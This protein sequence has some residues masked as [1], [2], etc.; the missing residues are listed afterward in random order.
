MMKAIAAFTGRMP[1]TMHRRMF[2]RALAGAGVAVTGAAAAQTQA[3]VHRLGILYLGRADKVGDNQPDPLVA[4]LARLGLVEGVNLIIDVRSPHGNAALLDA[5]AAELVAARP[6]VLLAGSGFIS[7]LALKKATT[8]IPIVFNVGEPVAAGLVSSLAH[9]GG[10]LTGGT[11]PAELEFKR[12]QILIEVLG[13]SASIVHLT[14]PLSELRKASFLAALAASGMAPG[15]RLQFL[16]VSKR[17]DLAP[18]FEQMVRQ[19]VGGVAVRLTPLTATHSEEIAAL[20]VKHRLPAIG[21]GTDYTDLG[22]LM[23]Y[24]VD[25]SEVLRQ[26]AK[27]IQRILNGAQPGDLPI[28]QVTKFEFVVNLKTARTLGVRVPLSVLTRATRVVE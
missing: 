3:K 20:A 11:I 15:A 6:D 10:N 24:S 1:A 9:P 16:E 22:F 25:W 7:A 23:S 14:T 18:A 28:E 27:Y 4:E 17:E 2:C 19:R 26:I 5:V 12:V 21:D 13:P 8:T